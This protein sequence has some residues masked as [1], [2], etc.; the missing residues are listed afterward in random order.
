MFEPA[1]AV[2]RTDGPV[3]SLVGLSL[4]PEHR[5]GHGGLDDAI[6][7][8]RIEF[9]RLRTALSGLPLPRAADGRLVPA[10]DVSP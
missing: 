4:A 2:L 8:G 9:D 5:R 3:R 6:N 1:D 7:N 10:V